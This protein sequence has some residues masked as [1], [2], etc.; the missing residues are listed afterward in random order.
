[1]ATVLGVPTVVFVVCGWSAIFGH[2]FLTRLRPGW[3]VIAIGGSRRSAY[4][5]GIAVRRTVAMCYVAGGVLTSDRRH[6]LR[7][8]LATAGGD[9]G[10]GLEV[11]GADRRVLG[12]ISLGGGKGSVIQGAGGNADR[13]ADHQRP[14]HDGRCPAAST[15]WCWR[16]SSSWP[17]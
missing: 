2:I 11:T 10:V 7:A 3:H 9:I 15:A 5:T 14:D 6:L 1:M 4:N 17:R 13:A 8:R 16:R 12:G